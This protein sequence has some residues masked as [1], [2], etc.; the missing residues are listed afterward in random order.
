MFL[1][2]NAYL[3]KSK[4][5]DKRQ[6]HPATMGYQKASTPAPA[7]LLNN[8]LSTAQRGFEAKTDR[9]TDSQSLGN[10]ELDILRSINPYPTA[11]P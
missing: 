3:T 2:K 5:L 6:I 1:F 11:F 10:L 8:I 4:T 9:R 7:T